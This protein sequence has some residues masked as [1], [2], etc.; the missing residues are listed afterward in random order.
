MG[1]GTILLALLLAVLSFGVVSVILLFDS[2]RR[3]QLARAL[4]YLASS[5][6]WLLRHRRADEA[7]EPP[8]EQ[9]AEMRRRLDYALEGL[10]RAVGSGSVTVAA[11]SG[12]PMIEDGRTPG[13]VALEA[14]LREGHAPV[15]G[16]P[17][18]TA[19]RVIWPI[20]PAASQ[21]RLPV[22]PRVAHGAPL[23]RVS[24]ARHRQSLD[25]AAARTRLTALRED[26]RTSL[27]QA[28]L[29]RWLIRAVA[30]LIVPGILTYQVSSRTSWFG[31]VWDAPFTRVGFLGALALGAVGSVWTFVVTRREHGLH[32][33]PRTLGESHAVRSL[34]ASEQ[35]ALRLAVGVPPSDAW[36]KVAQTNHFPPG[37]AMPAVEVDAA[38]ALVEALR[39]GWRRRHLVSARG[40]IAA[41][42]R[43]VV[44]CLLPA[45]VIIFVL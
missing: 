33:V 28:A 45:A 29:V 16:R 11:T 17:P 43:P 22:S 1:V 31:G 5:D 12:V 30:L 21:P 24:V 7:R 34:L 9:L 23:V 6:R 37:S 38:L 26:D 40:R 44:T 13:P 19:A 14:A 4:R 25:I 32:G 41:I 8:D 2:R 15:T 18:E 20:E 36:H 42:V 3:H 35:L 39:H 27:R 10:W